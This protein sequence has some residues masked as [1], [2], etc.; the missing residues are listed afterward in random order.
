MRPQVAS[1]KPRRRCDGGVGSGSWADEVVGP[2]KVGSG[3][4][5]I[6]PRDGGSSG[7]LGCSETTAVFTEVPEHI[8]AAL[9]HTRRKDGYGLAVA[10]A[11]VV[12][13][14]RRLQASG[15]ERYE[16]GLGIVVRNQRGRG[17]VGDLAVRED[18]GERARGRCGTD[19]VGIASP[20]CAS[21]QMLGVEGEPV[22]VHTTES[23]R[24]GI[25]RR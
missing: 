17:L 1:E 15:L 21:A 19:R 9:N 22:S 16:C 11:M 18:C 6:E 2:Q 25:R 4:V 20:F 7:D 14:G 3:R 10:Q 12:G 13:E 5:C 24:R 23:A 8:E